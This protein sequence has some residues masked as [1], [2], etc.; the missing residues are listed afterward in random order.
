M[1]Y[2][3]QLASR[4]AALPFLCLLALLLSFSFS[5]AD[6]DTGPGNW[7]MFHHDSQHTG[8]SPYTGSATAAQKWTLGM[9]QIFRGSPTLGADG[10]I[11]IG[12]SNLY[13]VN[14]DGTQQWVFAAG[15]GGGYMESAPAI[16]SDGTIYVGSRD[17]NLYAIHP[18]GTLKWK[19][20]TGNLIISS[21]T[22]GTDGTI[23]V[24]SW[25]G[26][27]Y[28]VNPDGTQ[29]WTFAAGGRVYGSPAIGADGAIYVGSDNDQ[30]YAVNP[31]GTQKWA[32]TAGAHVYASPA[33]GTDGTIYIGDYTDH[34]Y[35]INP[36]GT[37][38]WVFT[39]GGAYYSS[40]AIGTDGTIYV[41]A[42]DY[43][44]HAIN[45]DG[46][47]KW[48]FHTGMYVESS[49]AI[50]A[51]GTIYVGSED[52]N[53]YAINP[54]GTQK[55][56]CDTRSYVDSSPAIGPDGT[57]YVGSE[58]TGLWA[59]NAYNPV[60]AVKFYASP[61][62]PQ[63]ANT[64]ITFVAVATGGT[65]VSYQ[66]WLYNAAATPAW[67][68]LQ[69]YSASDSC[70]W[71][72][73]T[74]GKYLISVTAHD[75]VS[76]TEMNVQSW[77]TVAPP[78]TGISLMLMSA[79]PQP[80]NT[81]I[82]FIVVAQGGTNV[83]YQF[84]L[85]NP[86]ASPAWSQLQAYSSVASCHWTPSSVGNYLISATARDSI[87]GTD[88]NASVWY[89]ISNITPLSTIALTTSPYPP[90]PA[91][92]PIT[93]TALATG[94]TN[95]QYQFWLYNPAA[96]P[97]WSQLQAYSTSK[98]YVWTPSTAG[99]YLLSVTA[100]DGITGV[101]IGTV[102]WYTITAIPLTGVSLQPSATSPQTVNTPITL[103]AKATGGSN[104]S[105][106]FWL[107]AP[108]AT[109][110]WSQLQAYSTSATCSWTP[111]K[112]GSYLLSAT[113]RD[114]A[115]GA[116][117]NTTLWYSITNSTPLTAVA[118]TAAPDS[119][120][121][122][123]MHITLT[124]TATG[125]SNVQYQFWLYNSNATP[126]WRQLQ[127]YSA[128]TTCAWTPTSA[129]SYLLSVTAQDGATSAVENTVRWYIVQ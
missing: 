117:V 106:Q 100:R 116:E 78:L 26:K 51:D 94:G 110:A 3:S 4:R 120:Q 53:L 88:I 31:D 20:P 102:F 62:S 14:P 128:N 40:P 87:T 54:D 63:A 28:A 74:T 30:F 95:V 127:A 44:L 47:Q 33:I 90:R 18:D 37:P 98:Q 119:P 89:A 52:G 83:T 25:D 105:Y 27:L 80:P 42:D 7:G 73:T 93:L 125:G 122:A 111:S 57:I 5:P 16:G 11:Y 68:Q 81:P 61:I 77:Y 82:T 91:T 103:T 71:I 113:A 124:A 112:G 45:P 129:G 58:N 118:L 56:A 46:T 50:G 92:T 108:N 86:T 123:N 66:F 38:K 2:E 32:F 121:P 29:Q 15:E 24:G 48:A 23:Y 109:P 75:S 19:F 72:P 104:V 97:A 96:T 65:N 8:R 60:T 76:G 84:W 21:P 70:T 107:Y 39:N 115:T 126:A 69:G 1:T 9:G 79:P 17:D 12:A 13:A 67:G 49:P 41:G 64:A 114:G 10:T 6:G 55:W 43:H 22:I 34:F 99:N 101:E 36:D 35:A 59:I 85:Y